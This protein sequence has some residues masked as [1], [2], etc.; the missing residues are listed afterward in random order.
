VTAPF[1]VDAF[2]HAVERDEIGSRVRSINTLKRTAAGWAACNTDGPGFL[3]PLLARCDVNGL[4]ATVLGAGGA[5]RG[6]GDALTA[7][8]AHVSIAARDAARAV[9]VAREIGVDVATWPPAADSWDVLVNATPVGTWPDIASTPLPR[10]PFT[11]SL[12]YDLVYNPS[13]TKL[14]ADARAAGCGT[15]GG[16][17]MLVAQARR[18]FQWWTGRDVPADV[19]RQAAL[20]ALQSERH[21][22]AEP[23]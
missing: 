21:D 10:G 1:K 16:L 12:V 11:G 5:A 8:G 13:E 18:Q 17:E 6:V 14:L 20:A 9:R 7:A 19:M 4:R 2:E 23:V 15:L 3:E 22:V